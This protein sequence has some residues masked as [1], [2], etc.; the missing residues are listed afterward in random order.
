MQSEFIYLGPLHAA[1]LAV[2]PDYRRDTGASR[3][4]EDPRKYALGSRPILVATTSCTTRTSTLCAAE[5][6]R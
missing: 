6:T 4:T 1:I 2:G 5:D 3:R